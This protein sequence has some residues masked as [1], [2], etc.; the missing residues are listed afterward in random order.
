[1]NVRFKTHA[2]RLINELPHVKAR[3][4]SFDPDEIRVTYRGLSADREEAVA[5]YT[6]DPQDAYDTGI[7]MEK[8]WRTQCR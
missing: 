4:E 8:N 5:Y 2:I 1:M 7:Q 3:K 6:T